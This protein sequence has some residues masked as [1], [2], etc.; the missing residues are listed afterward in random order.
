M[1]FK[2]FKNTTEGINIILKDLKQ[3]NMC[4]LWDN[5]S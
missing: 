5:K 1:Q 3:E 4:I 2:L